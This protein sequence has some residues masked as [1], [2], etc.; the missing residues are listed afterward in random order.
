MGVMDK[1]ELKHQKHRHKEAFCLM[2]YQ[3]KDCGHK[4]RIWNSRDGVTPFCCKCPSCSSGMMNHE[5]WGLDEYAPDHQLI[6]FQKFWRDGTPDEAE[7]SMRRRIE[8]LSEEYP[9]LDEEAAKL[10]ADARDPTIEMGEF[11]QGWPYL[12]VKG[13]KGLEGWVK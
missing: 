12:D 6:T 3:C 7:T 10:I 11:R 13:R 8:L 5:H 1:T 9:L 4:E 2:W